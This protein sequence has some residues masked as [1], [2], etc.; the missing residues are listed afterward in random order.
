MEDLRAAYE[1]LKARGVRFR[2]API[3]IDAGV[4]KGGVSLYMLDPDGIT[5]ELFQ[6]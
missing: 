1:D 3:E 5:V 4:N 6:P 2:S